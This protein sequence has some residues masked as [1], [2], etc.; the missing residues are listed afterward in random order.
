MQR[1]RRVPDC[2]GKKLRPAAELLGK[3]LTPTNELTIGYAGNIERRGLLDVK[4]WNDAKLLKSHAS[5]S[6]LGYP[7]SCCLLCCTGRQY[8][9][10][11]GVALAQL[12]SV[13][14]R[15]QLLVL[16]LP[17]RGHA[18]IIRLGTKVLLIAGD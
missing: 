10:G 1:A 12:L 13:A 6:L 2:A 4:P 18:R 8:R 15:E 9:C 14:S 17:A 5:P 16:L 11:P 3:S 7:R